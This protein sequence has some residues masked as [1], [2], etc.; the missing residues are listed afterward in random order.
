MGSMEGLGGVEQ[1][2]LRAAWREFLAPSRKSLAWQ[3][4][5]VY[6]TGVT[7]QGTF[8]E[9]EVC[10]DS[11]RVIAVVGCGPRLTHQLDM[12]RLGGKLALV[13][14]GVACHGFDK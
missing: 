4:N 2:A 14:S 9:L 3:P 13:S 5:L 6:A 10:R 8:P 11:I 1:A 12:L 7:A